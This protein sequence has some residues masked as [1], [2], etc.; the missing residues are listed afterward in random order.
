M[1]LRQ[2]NLLKRIRTMGQVS[3]L[4]EPFVMDKAATANKLKDVPCRI[5]AAANTEGKG[6]RN[7][8]SSNH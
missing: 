4:N 3:I 1:D 2:V 8:G 6:D 5:S 7:Y